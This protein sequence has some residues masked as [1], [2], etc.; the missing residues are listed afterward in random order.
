MRSLPSSNT[1]LVPHGSSR[2]AHSLAP[3]VECLA[4]RSFFL[5]EVHVT[6]HSVSSAGNPGI[7]HIVPSA[8]TSGRW[9]MKSMAIVRV[10]AVKKARHREKGTAKTTIFQ[11]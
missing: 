6:V 1:A 10:R 7:V 9:V 11:D 5:L 3:I 8:G 4:I 2:I